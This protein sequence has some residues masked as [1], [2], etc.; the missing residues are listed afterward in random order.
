MDLNEKYYG[1]GSTMSF[2]LFD[3]LNNQLHSVIDSKMSN[4]Y[5]KSASLSKSHSNLDIVSLH[6]SKTNYIIIFDIQKEIMKNIFNI[7]ND[8]FFQEYNKNN[9]LMILFENNTLGLIKNT[10]ALIRN[11]EDKNVEIIQTFGKV[12]IFQWYPFCNLDENSFC[13]CNTDNEVYYVNLNNEK[14]FESKIS[15]NSKIKE[16]KNIKIV[17]VQ[18]YISDENFKYI[19]VGFDTSDICL[20]DMSPDN[21]SIITKFEKS[22]KNLNKLIWMKNDP[23]LFMA[24]Y[25]NS[26]K[27]SIFNVSSPNIKS[28]TKFTDKN[29]IN[30]ILLTNPFG[31]E[32][33]LLIA[34]TDGALQ[35]YDLNNKKIERNVTRGHSGTI[36][37]LKFSP[38][39]EG[40]LA[41]CSIDGSI[42]IWNI[43]N[44]KK[45]I[46]LVSSNRGVIKE[47]N[48]TQIISVKWSPL[49]ENK[50][51]LLCGDSKNSIKIWDITKQKVISQLELIIAQENNN[52]VNV[53]NNNNNKIQKIYNVI[54]L[55][56]NKSN[57]ILATCHTFIYIINFTANKLILNDVI[58]LHTKLFKIVFSPYDKENDTFAVG[59]LDCKIRIYE[60]SKIKQSANVSP[61]QILLGHK[62]QIFGLSYKPLNNIKNDKN[63]YLLASGSDDYRVGIWDLSKQEPKV[64][65]LLGH[66]DKVRNV[67]WFKEE[68][69]LISGSWDGLAFIW[70]INYYICLSII[71]NHKSDIYGI[72]TNIKYPYLFATSSRD[73][74]ICIF[75]YIN[76][77]IK[78]ILLYK[79][80]NI[81]DDNELNNLIKEKH[82]NLFNELKKIDNNDKISKAEVISKYFLSYPCIKEFYDIIKIIMHKMEHST[83]NNKIFHIT[84][85][86]SAYKSKILKIEFDYNNNK[87]IFNQNEINKKNMI[88][89]A[90]MKCAAINDWEKF[91][92]LNILTNNWKKAIMF[93]PK[94][95]KKYWEDLI[96]RYNNYLKENKK[97]TEE[98][99][100]NKESNIPNNKLLFNILESSITK[101]I[102]IPFDILLK[103][104]EYKNC[105]LLYIKNIINKN[106]KNENSNNFNFFEELNEEDKIIELI[107]KIKDNEY[108]DNYIELMKIINLLVNEKI[109]EN[110]IIEAVCI[111]LSANQ[112]TLAI[113]LLIRLDE[114][115]L[116]FYLMD[117]TQ[118]YLYEDIIIINLLK[119]SIKLN[120][121][122]NHISLINLIENKKI[123]IMLYK[124]LL[125]NNINLETQD[126]KEYDK[127]ISNI[128]NSN[129]D[130]EINIFLNI[131]NNNYKDFLSDRINK[132][133]ETLLEEIFD[134][135]IKFETLRELNELFNILR[136]YNF[137]IKLNDYKKDNV[138]KKLLLIIIFLE[139][140]NRNSFCVKLLVDKFLK[141]SKIDL[142][143]ELD[144]NEK[145]IISLGNDFYKSVNNES[146]FNINFNLHLTLRKN[147]NLK[148]I[149]NNFD[150]M[151]K[152]KNIGNINLLN[153]FSCQQNNKFY[154]HNSYK[155]NKVLEMNKYIQIIE[156]IIN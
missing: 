27:I 87:N 100:K 156:D 149:H 142:I 127:L 93:A 47:E 55:D 140:L 20:C 5:L 137:D 121:Y 65:F 113:K 85:L 17:N 144:E 86:Y 81:N 107:N 19:L 148:Q 34:L 54:G 61:T 126:Q 115:E 75:N 114:I 146:L 38:F 145:I 117:I 49:E 122:K 57:I 29:I 76:N 139:T 68:N 143:N 18:W 112:I 131:N 62:S 118:N 108:N 69:I 8:I 53:K 74:S 135:K 63:K 16:Y 82:L 99:Q 25:K 4:S 33:K 105:L 111:L 123:K 155:K 51:L 32:N 103:E 72:D 35:I 130:N 106:E 66:T 23:G 95:S 73:C 94:V 2:I 102:K 116:A 101:D 22:G 56:W 151:I 98:E 133:Y 24:F 21:T 78:N 13:Y 77:P 59:C 89:E 125:N 43:Y 12:I 70:D 80:N 30:C 40:I 46:T 91:C 42:K 15:L 90:I 28:I 84:D 48:K 79:S 134:E 136:I 128:R 120:S 138:H 10:F 141:F 92:E 52:N 36:F 44:E 96:L 37:D 124:L 109:A 41:T 67:V 7:N 152:E 45:N 60:I 58:N 71:K 150:K 1:Y 97:E 83:D 110:K 132:Y 39:L 88:S 9:N 64:R 3:R 14:K 50:E 31:S 104:K 147:V 129:N 6:Y 154:L 153:R 26:S 11:E 119:N